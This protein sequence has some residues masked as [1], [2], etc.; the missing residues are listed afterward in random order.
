M[1][2][3]LL[4]ITPLLFLYAAAVQ[5]LGIGDI[6][7][8]SALN[9]PF[10]AEIKLHSVN[11]EDMKAVSIGLASNA[12]FD[13]AGV[14]RHP[15]LDQLTFKIDTRRDGTSVIKVSSRQPIREPFLDFI[16]QVSWPAGQLQ[17]EYTVL[18]DPPV[19]TTER[20]APVAPAMTMSAAPE[21]VP[22]RPAA[23]APA[24]PER[25]APAAPA[26]RVSTNEY[27][28]TG[29]TDTLWSI[30]EQMRPDKSVSVPQTMMALLKGNPDAFYNDNIN[31]LKAGY[32]L[33]LEDRSL[34][35]AMS[36]G[37]AERESR[38]HYQEWLARKRGESVTPAR[39]QGVM[40][41]AGRAAAGSTAPDQQPRL[42]LVAP[43]EEE[44]RA[45]DATGTVSS[46]QGER[47]NAAEI[48]QELAL[49]AEA[50]DRTALENDD[51]K[52]HIASLESQ[53]TEMQRLLTLKD[54][55]LA[56]IQAQ[57]AE[58]AA[59]ASAGKP[60]APATPPVTEAARPREEHGVFGSPIVLST[61]MILVLGLVMLGWKMYRR[62]QLESLDSNV[63]TPVVVAAPPAA[64]VSENT[65]AA[66]DDQFEIASPTPFDSD[67]H[68]ISAEADD[69]DVLSEVDV[70]LA[71]HR[72]PQAETLIKG[73]IE[74]HPGR[75]DLQ[76]KLLEIYFA[77][78][79][80]QQFVAHAEQ[81]HDALGG[82]DGE[83]SEFWMRAAAL[84][85]EM[86]P[87]H[88]LFGGAQAIGGAAGHSAEVDTAAPGRGD[89]AIEF[90]AGLYDA[91]S[92]AK[93][94]TLD[95]PVAEDAGMEFT[96][97]GEDLSSPEDREFAA[98]DAADDEAFGL[99][100]SD[101]VSTKLDLAKAYVD[102]GDHDG[103]RS[104]LEEVVAE[105]SDVQ[106]QEARDLLA[107]IG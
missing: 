6:E 26:T 59:D 104:I 99:D 8:K 12:T 85:Q 58:Q 95:I 14:D 17:R 106:K 81:I 101:V 1:T 22:A 2:R 16:V 31:E 82:A 30:A 11:G 43:T 51:L 21:A 90:E 41:D 27:G 80:K 45:M 19:L 4:L 54:G 35:T 68:G 92:A 48:R 98:S 100:S 7:L 83:G 77:A 60:A 55:T 3:K 62:R 73:A 34:L 105:G 67:G 20:P 84:G 88:P 36:K 69:I 91:G 72:Y 18:L 79:D 63:F 71:Y 57:Q 93:S 25:P 28:P 38:R 74:H 96:S 70:Y 75:L 103:A 37:E 42:K 10:D 65:R 47:T 15:V 33:R 53:L 29:R 97:P 107:Q 61:V 52:Q 76:L 44:L 94:K 50:A 64:A 49:A 5:A 89:N 39:P 13:T 40:P 66:V 56:T 102:M 32:V 9:Q 23:T 86:A 46:G 78:Q 87:E 24:G